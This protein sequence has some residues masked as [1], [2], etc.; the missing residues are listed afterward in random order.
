[1]GVRPLFF[2]ILFPIIRLFLSAKLQ[3][4]I[5]IVGN[6]PKLLK[7]HG[8]SMSKLPEVLGGTNKDY[9]FHARYKEWIEEEKSVKQIAIRII[10]MRR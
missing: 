8:L 2:N 7:N 6:D 5:I 1:M 4:R 10:M 9:D 3:Q